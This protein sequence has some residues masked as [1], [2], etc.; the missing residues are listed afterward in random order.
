MGLIDYFEKTQGTGVLA[1]ADAQGKVD[2]ALYAR[3]LVGDG[4]A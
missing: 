2:L 1:T 4:A 3:P